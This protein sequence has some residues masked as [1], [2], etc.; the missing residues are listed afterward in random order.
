M[1]NR[2]LYIQRRAILKEKIEKGVILF[3]GNEESPMNYPD[4]PYP[5]RQHSSFLYYFGLDRPLLAAI[6]DLDSGQETVFGDEM[7]MDE[8]VWMGQKTNT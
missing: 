7:T 3:L 2:Q 8:I 6:I 5:F 4:N 1:F